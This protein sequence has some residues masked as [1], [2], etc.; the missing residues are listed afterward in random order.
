M[1]EVYITD[2]AA[3]NKG[4]LFGEWVELPLDGFS[5][6]QK[7]NKI[8]SEG[9]ELCSRELGYYEEHE[10]IFITDYTWDEYDFFNIDE[11]ECIISLN[12]KIQKLSSVDNSD[13]VKIEYLMQDIGLDIDEAIEK[14]EEVIFY[15][16]M[17][18]EDVAQ[19]LVEEVFGEVNSKLKFYIDYEK[20]GKDLSFDNYAEYHNG[21]IYYV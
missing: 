17:S 15:K 7:I 18:L 4:F 8:L 11:Y 3:Y 5:L 9:A 2:L 16:D 19:E 12:E 6:Q 10:E 21:V 20:L 14:K 1:L 13:L